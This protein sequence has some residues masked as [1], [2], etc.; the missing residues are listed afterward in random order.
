[1]PWLLLV[2]PQSDEATLFRLFRLE[3]RRLDAVALQELV[4]LRAVA[5]RELRRLRHAAV[6]ELENARE[7]VALEALARILE[8]SHLVHFDLDGLLDEG[9]RNHV[10]RTQRDRL[11]DDVVELAHV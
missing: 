9:S 5:A 4:E 11:L 7:V 6:R 8:R 10:G 3:D 2:S 1:M